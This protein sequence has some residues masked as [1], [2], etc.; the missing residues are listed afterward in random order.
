MEIDEIK[1]NA[2]IYLDNRLRDYLKAK[3]ENKPLYIIQYNGDDLHSTICAYKFAGL[4]N[5]DE[6]APYKIK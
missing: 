5:D 3:E 2:I 1:R 6:L 4:L